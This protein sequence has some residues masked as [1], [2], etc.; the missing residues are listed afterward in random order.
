MENDSPSSCDNRF[1]DVKKLSNII[2]LLA[3]GDQFYNMSCKHQL[4]FLID[5][6]RHIKEVSD[7]YSTIDE[8]LKSLEICKNSADVYCHYPHFTHECKKLDCDDLSSSSSS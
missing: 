4:N 1:E 6:I 7:G 2:N 8:S 5:S 3:Q